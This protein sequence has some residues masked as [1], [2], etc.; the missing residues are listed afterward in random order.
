MPS[1]HLILCHPLLLLPPIPPI[2]I[3]IPI[4]SELRFPFLTNMCCFCLFD[5]SSS[6]RVEFVSLSFYLHFSLWCW[7]PFHVH[8][9]KLCIIFGNTSIQILCPF[10]KIETFYCFYY[11]VVSFY[12]L[13][14]NPLSDTWI[15]SIF[16]IWEV[17][18][19]FKKKKKIYWLVDFNYVGSLL[20]LL[21]FL[22]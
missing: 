1:S 3:Y 12:S 11:W 18:F 21:G 4:K 19:S 9:G 14:V 2:P 13:E 22:Y 15:T 16:T 7:A 10:F 17:A 5:I 20:L 8:I 6:N